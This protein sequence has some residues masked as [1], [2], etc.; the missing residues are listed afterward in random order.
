MRFL[1][2]LT[3]S[4]LAGA[5]GAAYLTILVLQLNPDVPLLSA[6]TAWWFVTLGTLYGLHFAITLY[7]IIVAREFF[8]MNVFSPGWISVRLLAWFGA[9]L[10]A[11]AAALMW[12]NVR[13]LASTLGE[14]AEWRMTAGAVATTIAAV[15][16]L[17]IAI[18]H[19]SFGRRGSRVGASL[20][21]I[22]A[23]GSMALPVA[24]RGA[25]RAIQGQDLS[26]PA[27]EALP[28]SLPTEGPRVA[29]M[30]LDGASLEHIWP[31]VAASRLPNFSR[32]LDQGAVINLASIRPTNPSPVWAAVATGEYPSGNGIRSSARYFA[33]QD[34]R[35]VALLPDHS[36]SHALVHLG[37]VRDVPLNASAWMARPLWGILTEAGMTSGIVRWPL[38]H[39]APATAGFVVSDQ[40]HQTLGSI[41]EFT[42]AAFPQEIQR[43][44]Q[45]STDSAGLVQPDASLP[46]FPAGSPEHTAFQRDLLYSRVA[47]ALHAERVPDLFAIRY[48]G[49]DT[50]G[51]HYL[52]HAE[53]Q[54]TRDV[55]EEERRRR[56]QIVDRYYGFIDAELG[57]MLARMGPDDLLMVISG[58]GMEPLNPAKRALAWVMRDP[59]FTG[60]HDRGPDGFLLAYGR[61]VRPGA[62]L[63]RGSLVDITPTL[64]YFYGLPVARD[65]DGYAR[66]DVFT[67]E[68]TVARPITFIPSYR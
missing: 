14:T 57:A 47:N 4:L 21:M 45:M 58:F 40:L 67:Q 10:S 41:G 1:R 5:F 13:G 2:M 19:Y 38:T 64:L 63:P 24:A 53:G 20:F 68:F 26:W 62:R 52:R 28:P 29:L 51:H 50:V 17:A 39:P 60:T 31:R 33:L 37:F 18:A 8:T 54:R 25:G 35:G 34:S 11:G 9:A 23:A 56:A 43:T 15:V 59:A 65:M 22:A 49:L 6:T 7:V 12:M 30:L 44:V 42:R 48:E 27:A 32:V 3:N 46:G 55:S 16:L 61:A 36:L 66:A